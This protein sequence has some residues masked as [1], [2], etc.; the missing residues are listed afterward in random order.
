M[1][2]AFRTRLFDAAFDS[3]RDFRFPF[4]SSLPDRASYGS[5]RAELMR[6]AE[7]PRYGLLD[8]AAS[9]PAA[10]HSSLSQ[11]DGPALLLCG[12]PSCMK[13]YKAWDAFSPDGVG[14]LKDPAPTPTVL[15][16]TDAQPGDTSTTA[17]L[18]VDGPSVVSTL[19]TIGDFDFFKVD[20]VAGETYDIGQYLV[21]GGPNGVP[22]ADAYIELYDSAGNLITTADGGGPNTPSG[23][24]ALLTYQATYTGT[25]Y[26]NARAFDN[27]TPDGQEGDFVGD[28]EIFVT[29]IDPNDPNA[30]RPIYTPDQPMHSIDWGSQ[31]DRTVRNP[32]GENGPRDNG[33]PDTGVIHNSQ[34]NIDGKNVITYYFAQ[35]GDIFIDED[36]TTPGSTDTMVAEGF[37]QWEMDAF[38]LA[39]DQYEQV[40]DVVYIEVQSRAEA[41]FV[42]VTY[43]GTP[44]VGASLLGR[45][46]PPNEENE[47]RG[48]FNAG[49]ARWTEEGL[50]QG[51]FYF[52]TLLHELGHG[53]GMAHPHDNGGR[54][55]VMPG[56][57]G[58]TG[59]LGGGLGDY[60]LSQ[61]VFTI[62]S[63]N[64]GWQSS[65][66]GMPRS[67][68]ITGTEVDHYGWQ[69]T[70]AALDIAVI[71]DKY[72]VNE[73]WATGDDVYTMKDVN[74]EGTFYATIWDAGGTDEI[75]YAGARDANIDLRAATLEYEIGGGG[76]VSYAYGI[77]GG[78]TIANG[79]TIEN[80][81][82]GAGADT[83]TGN[84]ANNVLASGSGADTLNGGAGNDVLR[85][86]AGADALNGGEGF[87]MADFR[88]SNSGVTVKL[89]NNTVSGG[90]ASGDA[91]D[92]IEGAYGTSY[93][94]TLVG[95]NAA[96]TFFGGA[97]QDY[98]AGVGGNDTLIGDAGADTLDGG[99]GV[100][101]L[102]GGAANDT[103]VF[104]AGQSNGDTIT[105]FIGNGA[106]AGDMIQLQGYGTAAQGASFT[107]LDAT[108]WQ[109][110]SADGLIVDVVTIATDV[111]IDP[112]DYIFTG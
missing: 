80:A 60:L 36:P 66:Y 97:G 30:Y 101:I 24:D 39:L 93:A 35:T 51:G 65:P 37:Q 23:L 16:T 59:G 55:S 13:S 102:T 52:P 17:T 95:D 104:V 4:D 68:G 7:A 73:E 63:Y 90:H 99:A 110:T 82:S 19:D 100:D 33:A 48:E 92:S 18:T 28:Y 42:F 6:E 41:D 86:G 43:E 29:R 53:H 106:A 44:G 47:G 46:S 31:V 5:V 50:Q 40:A 56:A 12:C 98:I 112:S 74:A 109:I 27:G 9:L 45:M 84:D 107:Q 14:D 38:R 57:D 89:W 10:L 70:L 32:D 3:G 49:D 72:G 111:R 75:R 54:S 105:D 11:P 21:V 91:I 108:H 64:D 8:S 58:G 26:I 88:G 15:I 85:G 2:P 62:M 69:G 25:Y 78:F 34:F 20:L 67:G 76:W 77:H 22:L 71:Q 94:D 1:Y 61:Q 103:F 87:D 81:T 83:L 96:S 79:V